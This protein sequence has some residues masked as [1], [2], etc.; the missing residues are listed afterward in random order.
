[1]YRLNSIALCCGSDPMI[2]DQS[3]QNSVEKKSAEKLDAPS[4]QHRFGR[5]REPGEVKAVAQAQ[6]EMRPVDD[7]AV[8]I[9]NV[10][11]VMERIAFVEG[12]EFVF[13]GDRWIACG[14]DRREQVECTAKFRVKDGTAW[15]DVTGLRTATQRERATHLLVRLVDSNVLAGH[16]RIP[17]QIRSGRQSAKPATDDMRLHR[18]LPRILGDSNI[19]TCGCES[20][21]RR[22]GDFFG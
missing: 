22:I 16:P 5:Q 1:M 21:G 14:G 9:D 20:L 2:V 19:S 10:R 18:S 3:N 8:A 17:D 13:D 7:L 6:A 12:E 4:V 15:Q 11:P